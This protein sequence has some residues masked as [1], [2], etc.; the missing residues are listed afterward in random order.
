LKYWEKTVADAT[1]GLLNIEK[2]LC[3]KVLSD[4]FAVFRFVE[5][6][7]VENYGPVACG[8]IVGAAGFR[9]LGKEDLKCCT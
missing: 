1:T 3:R 5:T 7:F 9:L 6:V 8:G 2:K 4:K